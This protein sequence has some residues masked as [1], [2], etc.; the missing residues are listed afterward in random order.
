MSAGAFVARKRTVVI[1]YV[2]TYSRRSI[3][4]SLSFSRSRAISRLCGRLSFQVAELAGVDLA[5]SRLLVLTFLAL[6]GR[7]P[8]RNHRARDLPARFGRNFRQ[9][10]EI[11]FLYWHHGVVFTVLCRFPVPVCHDWREPQFS[12]ITH[13]ARRRPPRKAS[14]GPLHRCRFFSFFDVSYSF[15]RL[16]RHVAGGDQVTHRE[17]ELMS[18][19][20]PRPP[21]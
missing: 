20:S 14:Q 21:R 11:V 18:F 3:D 2:F 10:G 17:G 12:V 16:D 15:S 7:F 4:R 9:N 13:F 19:S 6:K 5:D 1:L 8:S